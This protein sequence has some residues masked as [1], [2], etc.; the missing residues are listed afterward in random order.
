MTIQV[1]L[2]HA[3]TVH[4][5]RI[6]CEPLIR[7]GWHYTEITAAVLAFEAIHAEHRGVGIRAAQHIVDVTADGEFRS[8]G[9]KSADAHTVLMLLAMAPK[10]ESRTTRDVAEEHIYAAMAR[11]LHAFNNSGGIHAT[12]DARRRQEDLVLARHYLNEAL[13]K[14]KGAL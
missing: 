14:I 3:R 11:V 8:W 4:E 10:H 5:F 1:N 13:T 7:L 9:P 6:Q 12:K 2:D